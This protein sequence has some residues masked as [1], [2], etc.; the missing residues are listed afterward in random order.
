MPINPNIAL[1]VK[2]IELQDPLAQYGKVAAIQNAQ[3][4]NALAQYQLTS[5]QREQESTNALNRAYTEAYNPQTGEVDVNKLRSSLATGGFGSK[6]PTVEKGLLELGKAKTDQQKA[7]TDLVDAKLK[8]SRSF[9]DTINPADPNAPQQYLAWHQSNHAD[10]V[11]GPVLTA[12]GVTAEQSM[13][14]IQQAIQQGPA[15]FAQLL[16]Q[17]KLGT[18]KFMELNKPTTQVVDQSGQRQVLQIPGLGGAPTSVGTYAD[19]PL[20]AA[21]EAQKSRIAKSGATN[22][23]VSTEKKYG[24]RFGGLIADQDAAKLSA[25]ENA[26]QAAATADR[27]MDL[28]STGKVITGTGANARLQLAK[29]LNLAGGTDSEKIRNTEVLVSSLA[30]TTLG[31]IKSSNLGAG[32]GFTNADRDFLEKAKAGQLSYDAKSLTE[33]ARLSRLAAEKSADSWN[34]RV[35]QIPAAALEGT[36]ISTEPVVVPPR[37][38][39]SVM[40]IPS[41][42]IQALQA[43]Q[44]TPEQFDA[45]FGAGSAARVLKGK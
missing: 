6:L 2:G 44:G 36:G 37:K 24:E 40:T 33:L 5:A 45:I 32:Q 31:A 13:A 10:P 35:Q 20:P 18:E 34:K 23:N 41:G 1:A 16:N 26:P 3:N 7:Q 38:T 29:A 11:L 14:R 19:V 9:L 21:V 42:A 12:R 39:S 17:S 25:A 28:I 4:Q 30:E 15:A 27:V 22:V 8:Q 43:G